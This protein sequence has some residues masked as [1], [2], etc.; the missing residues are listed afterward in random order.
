MML[1]EFC[2]RCNDGL[3]ISQR[4]LAKL[5]SSRVVCSLPRLRGRVGVRKIEQ[6]KLAPTLALPRKRGREQ[7]ARVA[8]GSRFLFS[9]QLSRL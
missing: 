5:L 4:V 8:Y 1:F 9:G 2:A 6:R 3:I 7:T